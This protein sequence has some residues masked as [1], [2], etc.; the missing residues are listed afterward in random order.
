M[1]NGFFMAKLNEEVLQ[2]DEVSFLELSSNPTLSQKQREKLRLARKAI[3]DQKRT[4]I[5]KKD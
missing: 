5:S 2:G 4:P 1:E 3:L